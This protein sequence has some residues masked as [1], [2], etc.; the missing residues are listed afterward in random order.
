MPEGL[1]R[2]R[3]VLVIAGG[4]ALV[5]CR[6]EGDSSDSSD[7]GG[8]DDSSPG[9][10][11]SGGEVDIC[12]APPTPGAGWTPLSTGDSQALLAVGSSLY[13]DIGTKRLIV[14]HAEEGCYVAVNR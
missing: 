1:T 7:A 4:I 14:A 10:D 8:T 2:R 12:A 5:S 13:A 3:A 6:D 9:T 11:D